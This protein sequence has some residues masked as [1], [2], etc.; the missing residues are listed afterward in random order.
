MIKGS[1]D[2]PRNQS[3]LETSGT[4]DIQFPGLPA[5]IC[6]SWN[7]RAANR[8]E[9]VVAKVQWR[10]EVEMKK[11]VLACG[12]LL[13]TA[14]CVPTYYETTSTVSEPVVYD[15][16]YYPRYQTTYDPYYAPRGSYYRSYNSPYLSAGPRMRGG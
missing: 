16:Y 3:L 12:V 9:P 8:I 11:L 6:H 10:S 4:Q 5:R 1:S 15:D 14:A 2:R 7:L 13:T